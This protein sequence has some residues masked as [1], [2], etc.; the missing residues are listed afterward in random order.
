MNTR[1]SFRH[2]WSGHRVEIVPSCFEAYRTIFN[3]LCWL[4][5]LILPVDT[6]AET[7]L[8]PPTTASLRVVLD[9]N[10]PPYIFREANGSLDGYLVDEW[11]LWEIK[12]G[13]HVELIASDW[14]VAKKSMASG[15]AEVIDTI[16]RTPE[17]D[18]T[19]DFTPSYAQIP[20]N[21]YTTAELTGIGNLSAL[22]G[23]RVG[24]KAGDAC[25]DKLNEKGIKE[26]IQFPSYEDLVQASI[27]KKINVFCM[28]EPPANYLVL[29]AHAENQI[30]M[31]FTL[32]TGEFHRAVHKGDAATLTLLERGFAAI[33]TDELKELHNKWM[34]TG[35]TNPL[36]RKLLYGL[37]FSVAIILLLAAFIFILRLL[38]KRRTADLLSTSNQLQATLD[39][40]PDLL[41]VVRL[42]GR[43]DD[44]HSPR[45]ELLA[46]PPETFLGK[47][48]SDV[49]PPDVADVCMSAILEAD[50]KGLSSGKQYELQ[51]PR[52]KFWFEL[53]VS[54]KPESQGQES[55]FIVLARD[56]TERKHAEER[57]QY[58]ANF[59]VLTGLPN[60]THLEDHLIYAISLAKRGNERLAVMFLDLDRFKDI[61]DTLGHSI[62]DALLTELSKRLQLALREEDSVSRLGGDEFIVLLPNIDEFGTAK[63]A[64]KLLEVIEKPYQFHQ[65]ELRVTAS[66]GI[67]LY[68]GDG[69]DLETL[70]K[71][72]DSAMYRAKQEGR[73]CYRF[74][75]QEMQELASRNLLLGNAL[76][77]ALDRN[78][79]CVYYQPQVSAVSGQLIGAEALLRWTHP[80]LGIISPAE[81]IPIAEDNGL[82][83]PIGEWVLTQAVHQAKIWM[84][85]GFV[86][87]VMAV[88]LSAVQFRHPSLPDLVTRI[89]EEATLPPEYLELELT[90]SVTMHDPKVL[91]Q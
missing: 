80:E 51:L 27:T 31:A 16:F 61:N 54:K 4:V 72:A 15:K 74:F 84:E 14:E 26:L 75:T 6:Y 36:H 18:I 46:A 10:Y 12:T 22:Q 52:G 13:V 57:V 41:F 78:Q 47:S 19:L 20:A 88:N 58:L 21:I 71:N 86:P 89:L 60:R 32:Y 67:A 42:N 23:F 17:R 33:T 79:L 83:L 2:T 5:T 55:N 39:A 62:G 91:L 44:Y 73:S 53:S 30:H 38:V 34:G 85:R 1:Q 64:Q 65:H 28:D 43:I 49:L 37:S 35:L 7:H 8:G 76:R 77:H 66:I 70:S 25:T 29:Q 50:T 24:V 56:I 82:I 9:N 90:E 40:I 3:V 81:F 48:F 87:L 59:D 45:E 11:K 69:R 68:P 63:V